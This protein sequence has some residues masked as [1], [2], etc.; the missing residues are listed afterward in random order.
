MVI[1]TPVVEHDTGVLQR[2][3]CVC[4][5]ER[6]EARQSHDNAADGSEHQAVSA[7]LAG[8]RGCYGKVVMGFELVASTCVRRL[9]IERLFRVYQAVPGLSGCPGRLFMRDDRDNLPGR[10]LYQHDLV[11]ICGHVIRSA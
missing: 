1:G 10:G 9:R 8:E 2:P 11:V 4:R 6:R 5:D 7:D 3:V